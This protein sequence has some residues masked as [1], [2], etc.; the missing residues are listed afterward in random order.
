MT[1][2]FC[3]IASSQECAEVGI[4]GYDNAIVGRCP[5]ENRDVFS[6]LQLDRAD[7]QCVVTGP[8]QKDSENWRQRV[9]DEKP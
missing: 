6:S 9:V 7:M 8:R 2:S 1:E 3:H 5:V 4:S